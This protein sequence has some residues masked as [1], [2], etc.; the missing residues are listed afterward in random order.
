M[1]DTKKGKEVPV[2]RDMTE[3][4]TREMF[5]RCEPM[6]IGY[7]GSIAYGTNL[8]TSDVDIRGIYMNPLD[9]FIGAV[10]PFGNGHHNLQSEEDDASAF[11]VQS[12]RD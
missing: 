11:A 2:I 3:E 9:E 1:I 7:G 8:P 12:E 10:L 5:Y 6:L 4:Q